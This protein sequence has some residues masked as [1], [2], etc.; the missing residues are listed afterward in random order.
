ML[1]IVV[2]KWEVLSNQREYI[3]TQIGHSK[4]TYDHNH[5]NTHFN[6]VSRNLKIPFKYILIT[7]K[8]D[9]RINTDIIQLDLWPYYREL[10]GCYHRLFTFSK[11]FEEYVGS[12]FISMDLD[13]VITSDITSLLTI[14]DDFVYYRMKGSNGTGWRMN[15]GMYMMDTGSRSF[16]WEKFNQDPDDIMSKRNGPG[17]DQGVTN[18][19][20]DLEKETCWTQGKY[21][22]DMRQDFIEKNRTELPD[23]C[24]IVMWPGPRD[25]NQSQWKSR[26]KWIE[27]YYK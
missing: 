3:P 12:R 20:L 14:S 6:M 7:D 23:D 22:F 27:E 19:L 11:E 17:T 1:S 4:V 13:M 16:V 15:N 2:F 10:G 5:V 21:I 8:K 18:F 25:P 24:R 9:D 26:Y